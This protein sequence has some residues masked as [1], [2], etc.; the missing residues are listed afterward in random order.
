MVM[1]SCTVTLSAPLTVPSVKS[2]VSPSGSFQTSTICPILA[3][4]NQ[5]GV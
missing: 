5:P 4:S 1:P 3:S 2:P